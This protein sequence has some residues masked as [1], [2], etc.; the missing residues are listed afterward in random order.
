MLQESVENCSQRALNLIDCPMPE[1]R[2]IHHSHHHASPW[3]RKHLKDMVRANANNS[4]RAKGISVT[5]LT[6]LHKRDKLMIQGEKIP[7]P[8]EMFQTFSKTTAFQKKKRKSEKEDQ[9]VFA[10]YLSFVSR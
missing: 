2:V 7:G 10:I 5:I 9:M 6:L 3:G 4:C 8:I 1:D